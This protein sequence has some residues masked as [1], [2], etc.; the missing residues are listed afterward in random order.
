[1]EIYYSWPQP[2][3][4]GNHSN[5]ISRLN[6]DNCTQR[7]IIHTGSSC[8]KIGKNS[9]QKLQML[10]IFGI[11]W[12]RNRINK[13]IYLYTPLSVDQIN[14]LCHGTMIIYRK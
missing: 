14:N 12:A 9:S 1:V 4:A 8:V 3:Q 7:V 10:R 5:I 2:K 6:C 11:D 13:N